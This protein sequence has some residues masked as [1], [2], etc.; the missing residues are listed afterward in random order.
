MV[1]AAFLVVKS[2]EKVEGDAEFIVARGKAKHV[3][4]M[5]ATI[6]WKIASG[7]GDSTIHYEGS[8][9]MEDITADLGNVDDIEIA[10]QRWQTVAAIEGISTSK[11]RQ[12]RVTVTSFVKYVFF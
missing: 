1:F 5:N 6:N 9:R 8:L 4:D 2:V 3:C 12:I 11:V 7:A 10:W